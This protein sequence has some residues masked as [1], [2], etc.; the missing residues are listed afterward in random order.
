MAKV[1]HSSEIMS[2]ANT[3]VPMLTYFVCG[4]MKPYKSPGSPNFIKL[5]VCP[6]LPQQAP[7]QTWMA[8][9]NLLTIRGPVRHNWVGVNKACHPPIASSLMY[10]LLFQ[11][12]NVTTIKQCWKAACWLLSYRQSATIY[13]SMSISLSSVRLCT[14][15]E[16]LKSIFF[17]FFSFR[18]TWSRWSRSWLHRKWSLSLST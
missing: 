6:V 16:K 2:A 12:W 7:R 1:E 14:L 4:L 9:N 11:W 13:Q 10:L 8:I 18:T 15:K 3:S 5:N 17:L